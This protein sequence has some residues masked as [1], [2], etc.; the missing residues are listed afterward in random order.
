MP[1]GLTV[2]TET[3]VTETTTTRITRSYS[4]EP[5]PQKSQTSDKPLRSAKSTIARPFAPKTTSAKSNTLPTSLESSVTESRASSIPSS[6]DLSPHLSP[7]SSLH[8]SPH[9]SPPQPPA[10]FLPPFAPDSFP[11]NE[12]KDDYEMVHRVPHPDCLLKPDQDSS[13]YYVVTVGR[14]CGI[15]LNWCVHGSLSYYVYLPTI[16]KA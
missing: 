2:M 15:F 4:T 7:H 5:S 14:E 3:I 8:L 16:P 9:S 12:D 11:F 10:P 6:P 1:A 13:H